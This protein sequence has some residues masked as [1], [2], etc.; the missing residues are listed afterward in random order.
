MIKS[1]RTKIMLI[2]TIFLVISMVVNFVFASVGQYIIFI[3]VLV[4]ILSYLIIR[5]FI[6]REI[7]NPVKQLEMLM[8]QAGNGDLT[9]RAEIK[10]GD[11]IETLGDYFNDMIRHQDEMVAKVRNGAEQLMAA[12]EEM[13]AS[14]QEISSASEEITSHMEKIA[15]NTDVQ[16]KSIVEISEVLVQLS[17]LVQ[18]AQK[19]ANMAKSNAANTNKT[20]LDGRNKLKDT[21]EAIEN[22]S[23]AAGE[24]AEK[25]D[26]LHKLSDKITG[27]V[28]TINSISEQ[29]N[30]L[31]LNAAIEAARAGEHGRGFAVVADEV[32]KLSEETKVGAN[33]V[34]TLVN[35]MVLEINSAVQSMR[36][37]KLAVD[38]GVGCGT[39]NG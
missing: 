26:K 33:E 21:V 4:M 10:T 9:V 30:L 5:V 6:N 25:L 28:S 18:I 23:N 38:K 36:I 24:T 39:G 15:D 16:N 8:S 13:D 19:R 34:A 22:I 35:V 17:S 3:D 12:S 20:A 29:T 1:I 37:G 11:E 7:I 14:T 31:A 2:F 32:R 27:I